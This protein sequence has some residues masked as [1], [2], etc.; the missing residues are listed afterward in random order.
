[1]YRL[2]PW[3]KLPVTAAW[4]QG[5]FLCGGT[6][7]PVM[8]EKTGCW[9]FF[10]CIYIYIYKY[11]CWYVI[12]IR[13]WCNVVANSS[14]AASPRLFL[15]HWSCWL[16][17][18]TRLVDYLGLYWGSLQGSIYGYRGFHSHGDTGTTAG[19][20]IWCTM[21]NLMKVD[22]NWGYAYD[23]GNPKIVYSI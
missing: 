20:F 9:V 2:H 12:P 17:G 15:V 5:P 23:S 7:L 14:H 22:E 1:M 3:P 19:W 18:S 8:M 13:P 21:E 4:A 6:H 16:L 11:Q 10:V